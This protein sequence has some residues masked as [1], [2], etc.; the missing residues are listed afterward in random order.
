MQHAVPE[1]IR[2]RLLTYLAEYPEAS[3]REL[4]AHLGM[5][6]GKINYCVRAL[7]EKGWVKMR[8]FHN[9][10]RKA[11]YRYLL[12]KK[13]FNK[14]VELAVAFLQRKIAEHDALTGEIEALRAEVASHSLE[15]R[16]GV[17]FD[18]GSGSIQAPAS[19]SSGQG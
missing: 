5:S 8:N 14:K 17:K 6:L 10:R 13:G 1:E 7:I 15:I 16:Q 11:G 3:Q 12:T 18:Q 2:Y 19:P 9:S 4:A